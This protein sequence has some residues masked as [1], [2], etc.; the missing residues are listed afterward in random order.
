MWHVGLLVAIAF[1]VLVTVP[2][3]AV[4]R[5]R[6]PNFVV[7]LIDDLGIT[8]TGPY[9]EAFADTPALDRL[10]AD[11]MRFTQAYAAAPVCSP[12]RAALLSGLYGPRTGVTRVI[13]PGYDEP[14][15][16]NTD[17]PL[18]PPA[19]SMN[20]PGELRT[21][22]HVLRDAGYRTGLVGKWHLGWAIDPE[23]AGFDEAHEWDSLAYGKW[24]APWFVGGVLRAL[25]NSVE[26]ALGWGA[27]NVEA[28]TREAVSFI[29]R[30]ADRPFFL[31]LSHYTVH[32]PIQSRA[33]TRD[34]YLRRQSERDAEGENPHFAA[35]L[36]EMDASIGSVLDALARLDLSDDTVVLFTSDN[37]G[38]VTAPRT[39]MVTLLRKTVWPHTPSTD[40]APFRAGKGTLYE[41]GIRVPVLVRWPR[42]VPAGTTSDQVA[43]S[44][45]LFP[46]LAELAGVPMAALPNDLDGISLVP[47]LRDPAQNLGR[48]SVFWH[49]PHY[50]EDYP[51][52]TPSAA[53]RRGRYKLIHFYEHERHELY[54]LAGDPGERVD[55][56]RQQPALAAQLSAELSAWQDAVGAK[57]PTWRNSGARAARAGPPLRPDSD[58]DAASQAPRRKTP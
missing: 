13:V 35:M 11:G 34:K 40:L 58:A 6:P 43:L 21:V 26:R 9:G 41:G 48:D 46:T 39:R 19:A 12:T 30:N 1:N 51:G 53:I 50:P 25:P 17:T 54:D 14:D 55:L 8:D 10:A 5:E 37:G 4:D 3:L 32:D 33:Q 38:L 16:S 52:Y 7:I 15:S 47:T 56:S 22:A 20:L 23:D 18:V 24:Y 45:D 27:Y 2:A 57:H 49:Y 36:E 29:E 28:L 42:Q 44:I 31:Y